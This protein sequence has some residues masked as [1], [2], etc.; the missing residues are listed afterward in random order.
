[1]PFAWVPLPTICA[2]TDKYLARYPFVRNVAAKILGESALKYSNLRQGTIVKLY[3]ELGV[4]KIH[5][6]LDGIAAR[7]VTQVQ[8]YKPGKFLFRSFIEPG[9]VKL[10][11]FQLEKDSIPRS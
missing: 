1:M 3:E 8:E 5:Q 10:D 11:G 4:Q 6:D 7:A 2:W 9:I